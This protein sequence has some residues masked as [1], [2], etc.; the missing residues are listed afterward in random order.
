M[1]AA[2]ARAWKGLETDRLEAEHWNALVEDRCAYVRVRGFLGEARSRELARRFLETEPPVYERRGNGASVRMELGSSLRSVLNRPRAEILPRARALSEG[3][4]R[5]YGEGE[6]PAR[7]LARRIEEA[8]GWR[9]AKALRDGAPYLP[10]YVWGFAPGSFLE[11]H[12]DNIQEPSEVFSRTFPMHFSW[13]V[14]FSTADKGGKFWVYDRR[15]RDGDERHEELPYCYG[16]GVVEG[17]VR[18]GCLPGTGDLI[19]F[20][21][22]NYHEVSRTSGRS[23]RIAAHAFISLD[24]ASREFLFWV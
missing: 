8:A 6:D 10:Q 21:S 15:V 17:A 2:A 11:L 9:E 18:T 16:R 23:S 14:F 24:P 22:E 13:N 19:I 3:L 4:R 12:R 7:L 1:R 20:N 5:F